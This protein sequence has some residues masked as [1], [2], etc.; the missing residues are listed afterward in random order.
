L[1]DK[2]HDAADE[3]HDGNERDIEQ[4]QT[5]T[6]HSESSQSSE[7]LNDPEIDDDAVKVLPGTGGPDDVGD[8]DIDPGEIHPEG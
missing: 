7:A 6:T 4:K 5:E 1:I 8:I 3:S 2:E